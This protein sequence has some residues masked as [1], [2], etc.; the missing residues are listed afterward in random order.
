M[1]KKQNVIIYVMLSIL[2][3]LLLMILLLIPQP[4]TKSKGI[5]DRMIVGGAF[6]TGCLLGLLLALRPGWI[7]R[8]TKKGYHGAVI[9][10]KNSNKRRRLGHHPDCRG[11]K[12]HVI[13]TKNKTLCAGCTGLALGS[14]IAIFLMGFYIAV[15]MRLSNIQLQ[16][17]ALIGVFFIALSYLEIVNYKRKS[18]AHAITNILLVLGFLFLVI[19]VHKQTASTPYGVLT[20]I[21]SFLFMDT[22][23][24]LSGWKH[25]MICKNCKRPCKAY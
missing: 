19:A 12:D 23:I 21:I 20:V 22:R 11:F 16:I 7:R 25:S 9:L 3:A 14:I 4:E 17:I 6:I 13:Q 24:Q 15:P 2:G 8:T 1:N 18:M 10:K 5:L